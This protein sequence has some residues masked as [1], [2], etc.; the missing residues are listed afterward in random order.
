MIPKK[1]LKEIGN[2][3]YRYTK[4][5]D[6]FSEYFKNCKQYQEYKEY[7]DFKETVKRRLDEA[8][9]KGYNPPI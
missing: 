8:E 5:E 1:D 9:Y 4:I 3:S 7:Q 2:P 6:S